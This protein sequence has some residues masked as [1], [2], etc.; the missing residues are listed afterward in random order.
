MRKETKRRNIFIDHNNHIY[1]SDLF[2]FTGDINISKYIN[3]YVNININDEMELLNMN[4]KDNYNYND[5]DNFDLGL[6]KCSSSSFNK[7][8]KYMNNHNDSTENSCTSPL[9]YEEGNF[10]FMNNM[11]CEM[12]SISYADADE[13]SLRK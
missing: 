12:E 3:T 4:I 9:T 10:N 2:Y 13:L 7:N 8:D 11:D 5:N 1:N 6:G